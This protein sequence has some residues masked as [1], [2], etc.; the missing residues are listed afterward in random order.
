MSRTHKGSIVYMFVSALDLPM[1]CTILINRKKLASYR[2]QYQD[3][4]VFEVISY[5]YKKSKIWIRRTSSKIEYYINS[6]C[7]LYTVAVDKFL[8]AICFK[9]YIDVD[10]VFLSSSLSGKSKNNGCRTSKNEPCVTF[11]QTWSRMWSSLKLE[12]NCALILTHLFPLSWSA[13]LSAGMKHC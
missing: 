8:M 12:L 11:G 6:K 4:V 10:P 1:Y 2:C 13:D 5:Y 7:R 3:P 9:R